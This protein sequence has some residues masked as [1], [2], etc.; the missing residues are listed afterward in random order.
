M[1]TF[2]FVNHY[3]WPG[4]D[5]QRGRAWAV[6][7]CVLADFREATARKSWPVGLFEGCVELGKVAGSW[8]WLEIG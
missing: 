7:F 8:E 2:V 6:P 5:G 1:D 4:R 3:G